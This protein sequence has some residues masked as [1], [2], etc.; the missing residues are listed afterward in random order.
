MPVC[1]HQQK[2]K[3][4][5][6][7]KCSQDQ[8]PDMQTND[9][10]TDSL[11][12]GKY[13]LLT[14]IGQGGW[15]KVYA[16]YQP[17]LNRKV[18]LKVLVGTED[19]EA[20][21]RFLQEARIVSAF[22]HRNIVKMYQYGV[23]D[24]GKPYFSSELLEGEDL[25]QHLRQNGPH[26]D[27]QILLQVFCQILDALSYAH[28]KGVVH[29]DLKPANVFL[30][31]SGEAK[32][33]DFGLATVLLPPGTDKQKLT[34]AGVV[35][36]TISYLSPEQVTGKQALPA[37]DLYAVGCMLFECVTGQPPFMAERDIDRL[38]QHA[39][40]LPPRMGDFC[41]DRTVP[42]DLEIL[43]QRA[44]EKDPLRRFSSA[45]EMKEHLI[46]ALSSDD[47]APATAKLSAEKHA[48]AQVKSAG[49]SARLQML[50]QT[51]L[52]MV[53]SMFLILCLIGISLFF[54]SLPKMS[55]KNAIDCWHFTESV[56][57]HTTHTTMTEALAKYFA[58]HG[59]Y[60][61]SL[62]LC[63]Q[64]DNTP[65]QNSQREQTLK[66]CLASATNADEGKA[67]A[68]LGEAYITLLDERAAACEQKMDFEGAARDR[69]Q[70]MKVSG[71]LPADKSSLKLACC[72][73]AGYNCLYRG[74]SQGAHSL[75]RMA[76]RWRGADEKSLINATQGEAL[77]FIAQGSGAKAWSILG[78]SPRAINGE[79]G[80]SPL[81]GKM[82]LLPV[83]LYKE[84]KYGETIVAAMTAESVAEILHLP[85]KVYWQLRGCSH[86]NRQEYPQAI[87]ALSK[88]VGFYLK[89]GDAKSAAELTSLMKT[90][91]KP[92]I[93]RK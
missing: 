38:Y 82:E 4:V 14:T 41:T 63:H 70:M 48:V 60:D 86:Y 58:A 27:W 28:F 34:A 69:I 54:F 43:V 67:A 51:P 46:K 57:P 36:G 90:C 61:S 50:S 3:K 77:V 62:A 85:V 65:K 16:A 80:V 26:F 23:A 68:H 79:I 39:H 33:L 87:N 44:L 13:Q 88:A 40:E 19:K 37:S 5:T 75:F 72:L 74:D 73:L 53:L 31:T 9:A 66:A 10:T 84:H 55:A 81:A 30:S 35:V 92:L 1:Q 93:D 45:D 22:N 47:Y 83:A 91:Q 32:V 71:C 25:S 56:M 17:G 89:D 18:A 7:D 29:R 64:L 6:R 24:D 8:R 2:G 59:N 20:A 15:G 11:F 52:S 78:S 21:A 42:E 49:Q 76:T 12:A